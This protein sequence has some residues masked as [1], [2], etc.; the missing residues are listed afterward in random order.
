METTYIESIIALFE[1][2]TL[3]ELNITEENSSISLK[4]DFGQEMVPVHAHSARNP[5]IVVT[6]ESQETGSKKESVTI[7][8]PIVGTFYRTPAPDAPPFVEIGDI[9]EPGDALCIIE[10]MK[11]MNR[12]EAEFRCEIIDFHADHGTL[13]QYGAPLIEVKKL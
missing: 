6:G 11:M 2:S 10:A 9:V 7:P 12:L 4:R 3:S 1:K 8:S 13:V 5:E